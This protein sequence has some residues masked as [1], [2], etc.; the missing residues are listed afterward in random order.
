M[1]AFEVQTSQRVYTNIVERGVT[2]RIRD[3]LPQNAGKLFL[4]TTEDVWRLHGSKIRAQFGNG[5][6]TVLFFPGGEPNKRLAALEQLAE[7]MSEHGADRKSLVIGFG[8]GIV[9]DVSGFLAAVFM[10]GVPVL[11][12]PTTL[13][14]QVDAATGGKTGV[15]LRSGKNLIGS[16]HQP[17]AVLIDPDV[18]S[19]LP[20]REYRAGLFEVIKCGVIR[21]RALF[22]LFFERADEILSLQPELV[23]QLIAGA[24]RIKAEVVSADEKEGDLRRILNFGHTVGHALEAETEYTRFLHGEAVAWGMAAATELAAI[25]GMLART[26]ASRIQDVI[27]RFG[28]LP[29]A[30]GLDADRLL[31]RLGKDKKTLGGRVHFVLPTAIGQVKIVSDVEAPAIRKAIKETL[32]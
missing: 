6:L 20:E 21:D 25:L 13:L 7:Q 12:I 18:L 8:G 2:G 1:P 9:T 32:R 16:F 19:T 17:I 26:E 14:A 15:N 4:V 30:G 31:E 10:R 22:D 27:F 3:F 23:E 28:P 29:S 5:E 11:Q 24:V